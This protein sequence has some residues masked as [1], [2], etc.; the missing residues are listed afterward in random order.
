MLFIEQTADELEFEPPAL[1]TLAVHAFPARWTR[2]TH[3]S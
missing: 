2:G 3:R 1:A